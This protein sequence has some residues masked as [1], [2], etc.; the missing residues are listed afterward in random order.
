[1]LMYQVSPF[2]AYP[3]PMYPYQ[4]RSDIIEDE[5]EDRNDGSCK[6]YPKPAPKPYYPKPVY[7][8]PVNPMPVPT[9]I[10]QPIN[11]STTELKSIE[12]NVNVTE[13]NNTIIQIEKKRPE[14]IRRLLMMGLA[15]AECKALL[16]SILLLSGKFD[17]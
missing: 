3:Q 10:M 5:D 13:I 4:Y 16:F 11:Y 2:M 17:K 6:S 14:V 9:K 7:P 1:M 8:M 12:Q 15:Y